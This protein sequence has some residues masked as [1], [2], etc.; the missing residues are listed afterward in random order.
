M[1]GVLDPDLQKAQM[2]LGKPTQAACCHISSLAPVMKMV[3][4]KLIASRNSIE[5][6]RKVS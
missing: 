3:K 6:D 2:A 5:T 4:N 1:E